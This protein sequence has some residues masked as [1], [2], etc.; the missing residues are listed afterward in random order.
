MSRFKILF[1]LAVISV[2]MAACGQAPGAGAQ[3]GATDV[4]ADDPPEADAP[5][6]A[7]DGPFNP[8]ARFDPPITITTAVSLT[9]NMQTLIGLQEDVLTNNNWFDAYYED[10]GI[11]VDILWSVPSVQFEQRVSMAIAGD[12]LPDIIAVNSSQLRMLVENGMVA[13]MTDLF[14]RYATDFVRRMMD[15]DDHVGLGQAT[16]NGRLMA[17]PEVHGNADGA[18]M[19]YIRADWMEALDRS[20][21]QTIDELIDLAQTFMDADLDGTGSA[22]GLGISSSSPQSFLGGGMGELTGFFEGFG[23]NPNGWIDVNGRAEFGRIQPAVRDALETLTV[24][25]EQ[26]LIHPEFATRDLTED[27]VSGRVGIMFGQHWNTFWPLQMT[28]DNNPEADWLPFPIPT[29]D[30]SPARPMLGGSAG[31]FY[32]TDV[33]AAYPQASV[34]LLNYN[35]YRQ[36]ALSEGFAGHRFHVPGHLQHEHPYAVHEWSILRGFYPRQNVFI[37][38]SIMAYVDGDESVLEN[39]WVVDNVQAMTDYL[40]NPIENAASWGAFRWSGPNGSMSVINHH[41]T[42]GNFIVNLLLETT[43][44]IVDYG[45]TLDNLAFTTFTRIIMGVDPIEA[46]DNFVD[47]WW[48]LGGDTITNEVNELLGR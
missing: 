19:L 22:F 30:G 9:D 13:D 6:V 5:A 26:G 35:Y 37:H 45:T 8:M 34:M 7:D 32:V 15:A 16:L 29:I 31:R 44:G 17:L 38:R 14:D 27:L 23:V 21:P 43:D 46:F 48:M 47:E 36:N 24:M 12:D 40:A 41:Q 18:A 10:L 3:A 28:I 2:I 25:Y 42:T 33:D 1:V 4:V 39:P 11:I 20:P